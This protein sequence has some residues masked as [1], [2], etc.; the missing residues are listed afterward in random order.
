MTKRIEFEAAVA[1]ERSHQAAELAT[2][3]GVDATED[4]R[5]RRYATRTLETCDWILAQDDAWMN[6]NAR[7]LCHGMCG[8]VSLN[9]RFSYEAHGEPIPARL[10]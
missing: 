6:E 7:Y 9:A 5:T 2:C 8:Q 1:Q 3:D 4:E 10:R